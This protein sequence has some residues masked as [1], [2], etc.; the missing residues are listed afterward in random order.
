MQISYSDVSRCARNSVACTGLSI[1]EVPNIRNN[2]TTLVLSDIN[3]TFQSCV[4]S[5]MTFCY[6]F[7][8][9]LNGVEDVN[10][11]IVMHSHVILMQMSELVQC[12]DSQQDRVGSLF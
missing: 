2:H 1:I 6:C 10:E 8:H 7:Y 9:S 3:S 12:Q 11:Q 4:I 5:F